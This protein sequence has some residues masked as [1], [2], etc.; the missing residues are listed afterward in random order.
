[1]VPRERRTDVRQRRLGWCQPCGSQERG[2]KSSLEPP[3]HVG[4][5]DEHLYTIKAALIERPAL[6]PDSVPGTLLGGQGPRGGAEMPEPSDPLGQRGEG[7]KRLEATAAPAPPP[8]A[9]CCSPL[10]TG[11]GLVSLDVHAPGDRGP[12]VCKL[13][14][15]LTLPS[16][17]PG[18]ALVPRGA[19]RGGCRRRQGG[20]GTGGGTLSAA[21]ACVPAALPWPPSRSPPRPSARLSVH[22]AP[23]LTE[24]SGH[25]APSPAD[26]PA[27]PPRAR[28]TRPANEVPVMFP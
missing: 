6:C 22:A 16:Q 21:R 19:T 8:T 11:P 27:A 17:A 12:R 3:T 7:R 26:P 24:L 20:G 15:M 18:E 1:M 10:W 13:G 14:R 28:R 5:G 4:G 25:L 9:P 2:L 23:V